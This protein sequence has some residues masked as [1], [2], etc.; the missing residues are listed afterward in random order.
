M[1]VAGGLDG[2]TAQAIIE[3][4]KGHRRSRKPQ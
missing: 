2:A 3:A 1:A 4:H